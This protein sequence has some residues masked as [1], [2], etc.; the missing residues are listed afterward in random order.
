[1]GLTL[2]EKQRRIHQR[3]IFR[4]LYDM[5]GGK[6][7][8]CGKRMIIKGT[9]PVAHE[10]ILANRE[11]ILPVSLKGNDKHYNLC[12]AHKGCN[13]KRG[14]DATKLPNID[15]L[16]LLPY[17]TQMQFIIVLEMYNP[18]GAEILQERLENRLE[19]K[20]K[21]LRRT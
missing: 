14:R 4:L 8:W 9:E 6:C 5:Q 19:K 7:I 3:S 17:E 13:Q 2:T 16:M 20:S 18:R 11:H 15:V 12:A 10:D 21:K 1:M